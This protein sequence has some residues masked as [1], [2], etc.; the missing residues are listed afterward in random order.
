MRGSTSVHEMEDVVM[1]NFDIHVAAEGGDVAALAEALRTLGFEDDNLASREMFF[2]SETARYYEACPLIAVHVSRKCRDRVEQESLAAEVD[3]TACATGAVGY[4]HSE[5]ARKRVGVT[6]T[7]GSDF[8]PTP[9]PFRRLTPRPRPKAKKWDIHIRWDLDKSPDE[10]LEALVEQGGFYYLIRWREGRKVVV[11]TIQGINSPAE[12]LRLFDAT[13]GWLQ[14]VGAPPF[15]AKF[16]ITRR[17]EI[18][19]S[20]R[21]VPPTIEAIEWL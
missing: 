1:S 5:Y 3:A 21:L 10:L 8:L 13:C 17:M 11:P 19:G 20:P 6:E 14:A 16:E 2:D 12:G 4:G 18:W 9:L 15:D 7:D